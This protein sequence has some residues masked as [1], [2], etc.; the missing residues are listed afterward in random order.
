MMSGSKVI[1]I[2]NNC[3]IK[4]FSKTVPWTIGIVCFVMPYTGP[5]I[6]WT[7]VWGDNPI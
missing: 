6:D 7:K 3:L 1:T 2:G 5:Q 4:C